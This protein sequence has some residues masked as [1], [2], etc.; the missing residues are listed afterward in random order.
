VEQNFAIFQS[1]IL[2]PFQRGIGKGD[3]LRRFIMNG[4]E[5]LLSG[6]TN[7]AAACQGKDDHALAVNTPGDVAKLIS[8]G[9]GCRRARSGK[10]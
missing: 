8:F 3:A 10:A 6:I 7:T 4:I 5:K 9:F 2:S 1:N